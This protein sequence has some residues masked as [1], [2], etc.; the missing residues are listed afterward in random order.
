MLSTRAHAKIL[1]VDAS[2]ALEMPNVLTYVD[3]RDLPS[4]KANVWGPAVQDEFFFAV[5]EVTSHGGIIGA[6]VATNKIDAQKAARAVKIEY[7]DL[8]KILTIDEVSEPFSLTLKNLTT[9]PTSCGRLSLPTLSTKLTIAESL[10]GTKSRKL[11]PLPI[12]FLRVEQLCK[13]KSTSIW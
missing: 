1:S 4:P 9:H 3:H 2:A 12:S 6:I 8:P 5:D 13:V 7:E 11:S 10:V